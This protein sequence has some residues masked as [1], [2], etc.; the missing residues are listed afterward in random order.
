MTRRR[1][2]FSDESGDLQFRRSPNVSKYF[3]VGTLVIEEDAL[4]V[5][6]RKMAR[7]RDE[8][9][10]RR[11]GLDSA[12]H[13]TT[14]TYDVRRNVFGLLEQLDFRFDITLFEKSKAVPRVRPDGPTAFRYAWYYHL[15]YVAPKVFA[16]GDEV[17]VVAA[18]LGTKRERKEFRGAIEEVLTQCVNYRVKRT[19]AFW[20][21][22]SD[23]ALQAVDYCTWAVM[24]KYE[25]GDDQYYQQIKKKIV[26]EFDLFTPGT[27]HWY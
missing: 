23:F 16:P 25:R 3:A 22:E 6:R 14:D 27:R 4:G 18:S 1:Y 15:R 26:T 11:H 21:D 20:R 24:R 12:F 8:L 17:L 9:A 10:W 13:A 19:L 5:L 2:L 7:L